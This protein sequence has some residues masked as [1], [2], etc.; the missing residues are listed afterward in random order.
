[1]G[2]LVV[3]GGASA[4][5]T[6]PKNVEA[7]TTYTVAQ[8]QTHNTA[9]DC[10]SIVNGKVYNLTSYAPFHPGGAAA[11]NALCGTNATAIFGGQHGSSISANSMLTSK[12]LGDIV[13]VADTI[14]PTVPTNLVSPSKTKNLVKLTW[15][16]SADNIAVVG[17]KIYKDGILLGNT[18]SLQF[19]ST[20]LTASTSYQFAIAAYDVAGNISAKTA[21]IT[22]VTL[23]NSTSTPGT[24]TTTP[25][26]KKCHDDD[27][28]E[29]HEKK[30]K[31]Y[32]KDKRHAEY[33]NNLNVHIQNAIRKAEKNERD[34]D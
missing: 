15:T 23:A 32:K 19:N 34:N 31:K 8:V 2:M 22:V 16:A 1:M 27:K 33:R 30:E 25:T 28:D 10:W 11:I 5:L 14:V 9:S 13:V 24:G 20:G 18:S 4:L 21:T 26:I 3:F 29:R 12:Y 6:T 17:Y 7:A